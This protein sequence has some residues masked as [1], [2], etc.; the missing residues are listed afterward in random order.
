MFKMEFIKSSLRN[1]C[2]GTG[3]LTFNMFRV[4]EIKYKSGNEII[5]EGRITRGNYKKFRKIHLRYHDY[6]KLDHYDV[7]KY[8]DWLWSNWSPW[9]TSLKI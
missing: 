6:R 1:E 2:Y 9:N 8:W 3:L 4:G 7:K 5:Y